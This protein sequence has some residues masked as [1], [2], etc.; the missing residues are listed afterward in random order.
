MDRG[1]FDDVLLRK[2]LPRSVR[3]RSTKE[4]ILFDIGASR[5]NYSFTDGSIDHSDK[6]RPTI[7][8]YENA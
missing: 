1:V 5:S 4:D 7:T 2:G 8:S 3:R 6:S